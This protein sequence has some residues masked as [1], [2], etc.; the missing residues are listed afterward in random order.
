MRVVLLASALILSV[1][2]AAMASDVSRE[3]QIFK[4]VCLNNAPA[5]SESAISSA[6]NRTVYASS[7][8]R[9]AGV[10]YREGQTC[11]VAFAGS[12]SPSDDEIK[13]M[14][15]HF[16][17][18]IGGTVY[19]RKSAIGGDRWYEVRVGRKKYGVEGGHRNGVAYFTIAKR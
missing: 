19:A 8:I 5:F 14:A 3:A 9:G 18:R 6:A 12:F 13:R 17:K 16:S 1:S 7:N 10:E 15:L 4:E 11:K 2:S